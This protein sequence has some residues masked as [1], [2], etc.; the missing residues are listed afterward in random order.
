M[1][2][3]GSGSFPAR[4]D[5]IF[6]GHGACAPAHERSTPLSASKG[7]LAVAD[8]TG[9]TLSTKLDEWVWCG[10]DLRAAHPCPPTMLLLLQIEI[11][12]AVR[13]FESS[14]GGR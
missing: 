1:P 13:F 11:K 3:Y 9:R 5:L 10:Y 2:D 14:A 8:T 12:L 7:G 4:D 6:S